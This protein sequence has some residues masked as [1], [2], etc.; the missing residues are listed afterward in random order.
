MHLGHFGVVPESAQRSMQYRTPGWL[1]IVVTDDVEQ[2][3]R[4]K[5]QTG[6][7]GF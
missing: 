5:M 4:L 2:P 3:E 7:R 6:R 1:E